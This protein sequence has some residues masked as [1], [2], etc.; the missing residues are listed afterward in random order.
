MTQLDSGNIGRKRFVN[1]RKL[2]AMDIVLHGSRF[3]LIEFG[4][5]AIFCGFFGVLSLLI[6][7]TSPTHPGF[8]LIMGCIL[9]WLALNCVP[10]LLYAIDMIRHKS[11]RR[12]LAFELLH[13]DHYARLYT[14]QSVLLLLPLIVPIL[15]IHQEFQKRAHRNEFS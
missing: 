10:L 5:G 15:A 3:I 7:F 12:E 6:Y 14:R 4:A 13:K 9:S 11:V 2:A 8:S 1:I